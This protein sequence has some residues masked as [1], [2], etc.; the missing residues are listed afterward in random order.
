MQD[1]TPFEEAF[2]TEYQSNGFIASNAWLA[3]RPNILKSSAETSSCKLLA[4]PHIK[5]ALQERLKTKQDLVEV[6]KPILI[7]DARRI[8][9]KAEDKG[10]FSAALKSVDIQANLTGAYSQDEEDSAKYTA[11]INQLTI[12]MSNKNEDIRTIS[13][14]DTQ[15]NKYDKQDYELVGVN[16]LDKSKVI[17]IDNDDS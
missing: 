17:D 10:Q 13:N 8:M 5:A 12:N 4:E 6:N 3:I 16:T 9:T 7:K 15:S 11:F 14:K 2:L 1:L